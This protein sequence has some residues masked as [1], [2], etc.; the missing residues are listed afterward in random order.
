MV[1]SPPELIDLVRLEAACSAIDLGGPA[2]LTCFFNV[3]RFGGEDDGLFFEGAITVVLGPSC[4]MDEEDGSA[5]KGK[6][7]GVDGGAIPETETVR[8]PRT[9][10]GVVARADMNKALSL[11][12]LVPFPLVLA[13]VVFRT[14]FVGDEDKAVV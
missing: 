2:L 10:L 11:V 8:F 1:V 13:L 4:G 14:P 12:N 6:A 9:V 7:A 5:R 3:G